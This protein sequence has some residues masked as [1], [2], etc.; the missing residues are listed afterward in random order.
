MPMA[1]ATLDDLRA[2]V[3]EDLERLRRIG[4]HL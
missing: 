2:Q 3:S 1:Y 4:G